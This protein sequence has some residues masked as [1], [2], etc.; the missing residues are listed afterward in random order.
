MKNTENMIKIFAIPFILWGLYKTFLC[1]YIMFTEDVTFSISNL[2]IYRCLYY[3]FLLFSGIGVFVKKKWGIILLLIVMGVSVLY[4]FYNDFYKVALDQFIDPEYSIISKG[5]LILFVFY[6]K[7][8]IPLFVY[9]F[10]RFKKIREE[11]A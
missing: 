5:A 1:L 4:G 9:C 8:L 11:F 10:F 3:S 7:L 6:K 2:F